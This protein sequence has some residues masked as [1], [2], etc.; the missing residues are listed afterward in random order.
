MANHS[1]VRYNRRRVT[2]TA[3]A[4][5]MLLKEFCHARFG[6]K[7]AV[8][9]QEAS[10]MARQGYAV[11]H[12]VIPGSEIADNHEAMRF[13]VAPDDPIGF[14]VWYRPGLLEFRHVMNYW[15]RWAQECIEEDFAMH[16]KGTMTSDHDDKEEPARRESSKYKSV[17]AYLTRNFKETITADDAEWIEK[18]MSAVPEGFRD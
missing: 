7:V 18:L 9:R 3:S 5:E 11:W 17:R 12:C 4:V 1:Y 14:P 15:A 10:H 2:L 6:D 8:V 13:Y 16:T